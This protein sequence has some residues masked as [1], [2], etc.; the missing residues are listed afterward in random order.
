MP[1]ISQKTTSKDELTEI[2]KKIK[3]VQINP[4]SINLPKDLDEISDPGDT[5]DTDDI[6]AKFNHDK[7]KEYSD[8]IFYQKISYDCGEYFKNC[9]T[10]KLTDKDKKNVITLINKIYSKVVIYQSHICLN[11]LNDIYKDYDDKRKELLVKIQRFVNKLIDTSFP[12]RKKTSFKKNELVLLFNNTTK[13]FN[14]LIEMVSSASN[15]ES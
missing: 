9:S 3:D 14:L 4:E 2:V 15:D 8:L 11:S 1:K 5:D 10:V 12:L 6:L 7:F 13:L